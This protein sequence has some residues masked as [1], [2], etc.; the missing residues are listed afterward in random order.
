MCA[1]ASG[2]DQAES[3]VYFASGRVVRALGMADDPRR[4]EFE[5]AVADARWREYAQQNNAKVK[6][7]PKI[8]RG[9]ST[10]NSVISHRW[11]SPDLFTDRA[12]HIRAMVLR[13]TEGR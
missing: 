11:V 10:G 4:L 13:A 7:A 9:P 5:I 1:S 3:E 8:K 2:T 12:A 6:S